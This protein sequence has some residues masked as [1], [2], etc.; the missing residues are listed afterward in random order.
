MYFIF[1]LHR[2]GSEDHWLGQL[3]ALQPPLLSQ[4]PPKLKPVSLLPDCPLP[5][6]VQN[7]TMQ[8]DKHR[9]GV[10][11]SA[12]RSSGL[13]AAPFVHFAETVAPNSHCAQ[14]RACPWDGLW[15]TGAFLLHR[16]PTS[17]LS[18][19]PSEL[20]GFSIAGCSAI[21]WGLNTKT[22]PNRTVSL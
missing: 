3:P 15:A 13:A 16:T 22:I 19:K 20:P 10:F 7:A 14:P 4:G 12:Q 9:R 21:S 1:F 2:W 8:S 11:G 17:T 6:G 18:W 5:T